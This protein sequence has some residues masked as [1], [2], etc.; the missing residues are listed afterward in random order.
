MKTVRNGNIF[1]PSFLFQ[2]C[3]LC[4]CGAHACGCRLMSG[5]I[6]ITFYS[7]HWVRTT[8]SNPGLADIASFPHQ[9]ALKIPVSVFWDGKTSEPSCLPG[10]Y[11][12]DRDLNPGPQDWVVRT[13]TTGAI[14]SAPS[15]NIFFGKKER[16]TSRYKINFA[17]PNRHL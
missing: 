1:F 14:S 4:I 6:L 3:V 8:Q 10:Y 17:S 2:V 9:L 16:H 11:V 5:L 13:L 7:I 15:E 12:G